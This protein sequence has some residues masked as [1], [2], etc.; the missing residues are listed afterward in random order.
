MSCFAFPMNDGRQ[1]S[2]LSAVV[3]EIMII[4][5]FAQIR[6]VGEHVRGKM[7]DARVVQVRDVNPA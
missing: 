7:P 1:L 2:D 4:P 5:S 6:L 3:I